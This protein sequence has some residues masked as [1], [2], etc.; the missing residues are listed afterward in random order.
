MLAHG[1]RR[2]VVSPGTTHM[3]IVAGLQ[4]NG[5]FEMYSCIDERGA[6]YM[7]CGMAEKSG[8]P[9]AIIC[10]ESVA[11]RNYNSAMTDAYYR[12][13]PILAITGAHGY[14]K[15]G[16]LHTQI[17]DRSVSPNDTFKLKVQLPAIKS[18]EDVWMSNILLNKALL[19]LKRS[20]GGPVHIDMPWSE[21][22]EFSAKELYKTRV[23]RRYF[24]EDTLPNLVGGGKIAVFLGTHTAF[25]ESQERA[26]D[27]FCAANDAV[28][29][30]SHT[31]GYRGKYAVESCLAAS[32][33]TKYSI[34]KDIK[35][36]IHVGGPAADEST[37]TKLSSSVR[38]VWRVSPDGELRDT[39][40]KLTCVFE[41]EEEEFFSKYSAEG[42]R[43][44]DDFLKEC[45][46]RI[47]KI[48][49][50]VKDLPFS[51]IY[52]A[53]L[54]SKQL[55]D[56]ALIHFGMSNS[57]R[58][59]SLFSFA[60]RVT[61][62]ANSGTR[63]IDGVLSAFLGASLVNKDRLCFCVLGDLAF[64]YD[65]NA[66][67]NESLGK[68]VRILLVNNDGGGLMKTSGSQVYQF[69]GDVDAD[70]YLVAEGHF[71]GS[72]SG[73]VKAYAEA[74]GFEYLEASDKVSFDTVYKRFLTPEITDRPILL[75][76]FTDAREDRMA[77]DI[78][79]S[80]DTSVQGAVKTRL[81][82]MLGPGRVA[83]IKKAIHYG[84][85]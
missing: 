64:F 33:R 19:E 34:F 81:K 3:E 35:V 75:E 70:D 14:S 45:R 39:F 56:G 47:D 21:S 76:V 25:S 8:D 44:K 43:S 68:N 61:G 80:I 79:N 55:P 17:I 77:F 36:L 85:G 24:S 57:L 31:S 69:L 60:N 62:G 73:V 12:Q 71:G 66:L 53:S 28:V 7:A 2:V 58:A 26:L 22:K 65:I 50:P 84:N 48:N 18:S 52:I 6:A 16:H 67:Q 27:N 38:E 54:L 49:I 37:A 9:V 20:G 82:Q 32:Q 59:W 4:L 78:M 23:I 83:K 72:G 40:K 42:C 13:L 29:F 63:G 5:G 11:S 15:I 1:V 41:M 74:L 10:T 46:R 51:N 30:C